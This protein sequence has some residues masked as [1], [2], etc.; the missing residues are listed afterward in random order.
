MLSTDE[1]VRQK[2]QLLRSAL[3]NVRHYRATV[4][5]EVSK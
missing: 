3:N 4:V 2:L 1:T 5:K